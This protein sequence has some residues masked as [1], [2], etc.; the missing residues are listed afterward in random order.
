MVKDNHSHQPSRSAFLRTG[1]GAGAV[2]SANAGLGMALAP[3]VARSQ[4]IAPATP[5]QRRRQSFS[6]RRDAAHAYLSAPVPR[7][8]TNGDEA[9]YA[10]N[11]R[12][13]LRRCRITIL[14]KLTS[15]RT[16]GCWRHLEA[17]LPQIRAPG[18][19]ARLCDEVEQSASRL[20]L[21]SCGA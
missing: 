16:P 4:E 5:S 11:A 21:R 8:V 9:R 1:L 12:V 10:D 13:F 14:V 15:A 18:T 7:I 17:A 3:E 6:L 19:R 2:L 20:R